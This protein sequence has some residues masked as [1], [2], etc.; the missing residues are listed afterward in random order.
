MSVVES[1]LPDEERDQQSLLAFLRDELEG[2]KV[3]GKEWSGQYISSFMMMRF[4]NGAFHFYTSSELEFRDRFCY[5][6]VLRMVN[7][8]PPFAVV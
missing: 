4:R 8:D 1:E 7:A 2:A 5:R 6:C 3:G